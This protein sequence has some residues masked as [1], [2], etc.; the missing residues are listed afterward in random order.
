MDRVT[1]ATKDCFDAAIQLRG[2]EASAVPPPE[3]LHHRLRGVVDET[4]RRAAVLGF[5]HQDAQDMAYALVAL[6][7]EVVLGRPEEY[8]QLWMP[9]QLHYFNENVAGDGFFAR[10]NTVRK[11]PHRH[12]VL[13]VYYLCMLFGFQGRYRIRGGELELM[14]LIDTVQ[15]DLERARPFDFDVLS[16]HGD[17][18]TESLLSKRKKAS[19]VG[20][21]AGALAVAVL[22]YGVLQFFLNDKVGELRSRIEVHA[23]R[24]TATSASQTQAAGGAQ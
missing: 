9:L 8:R 24:N 13:Q 17:R 1:E 21:S 7:D 12:E 15:K 11:D 20:I 23:A 18:P 5:S 4:L 6:I 14:T 10:L 2:S 3:T 19:M 16:P 22:F